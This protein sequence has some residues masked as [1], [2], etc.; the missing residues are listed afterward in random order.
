MIGIDVGTS[1]VKIL[2]VSMSGEVL[3]RLERTYPLSSPQPGWSEQD[4]EDWV[5]ATEGTSL[6]C[7][8]W[9]DIRPSRRKCLPRLRED[10]CF[11]LSEGHLGA[12]PER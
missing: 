2:A 3:A 10:N 4:P 6:H 12:L 11:P 1:G 5:R 7:T 8:R 9:R